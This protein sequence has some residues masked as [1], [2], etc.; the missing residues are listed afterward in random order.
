[1]AACL[2]SDEQ[3]DAFERANA[4]AQKMVQGPKTTGRSGWAAKQEQRMWQEIRLKER[5]AAFKASK[6]D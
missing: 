1:M 3:F 6:G 2:M 4:P 5:E